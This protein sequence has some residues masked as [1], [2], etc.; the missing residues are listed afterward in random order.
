MNLPDLKEFQVVC[1]RC[2]SKWTATLTRP[3]GEFF[4]TS[5][6]SCVAKDEEATKERVHRNEFMARFNRSN[7]PAALKRKTLPKGQLRDLAAE[8][9]R[10]DSM[11]LTVHGPVGSG[12]THFAAVACRYMLARRQV[13]WVE[14]ARQMALLSAAFGDDERREALAAFTGT[15]P[16]VFDDFD[17]VIEGEKG[18]PKLFAALDARV[19]REVPVLVTMNSSLDDLRDRLVKVR[20]DL[21]EPIVSRLRGGRI[22]KLPG[23]DRRREKGQVR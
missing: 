18:L 7:L 4:D 19:A 23:R 12:K 22:V 1:V 13:M 15:G 21:A 3:P 20:P 8:W 14:V 9:A 5:C 16:V 6:S 10:S 11:V 17:K 2:G